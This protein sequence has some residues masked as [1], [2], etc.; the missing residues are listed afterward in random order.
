MFP[1]AAVLMLMGVIAFLAYPFWRKSQ[2]PLIVGHEASLDEER[3]D[4][5]IE[6]QSLLKILSDLEIDSAQGKIAAA[7]YTRL[8][9]SNEHRL[10]AVLD[11]LDVLTRK[12]SGR[13][14]VKTMAAPSR[15]NWLAIPV[16]GLLIAGGSA[17]V[18]KLVYMRFEQQQ[19]AAAAR[20]GGGPPINP[21]EMVA[22][23]E[24][25]LKKNPNDLQGQ[26]MAG[27]SY[28][29]LE[30]WPEAEKAW[31]KVLE[32]D[33]KN[34]TA[35]YSLGEILIRTAA[36]GNNAVAEEA[37]SHFDKALIRL[38]QDPSILWARGIA[39]VQLGRFPEADEAWTQAFQYLPQGTESSDMVKKAL[40]DLR[41]GRIPLS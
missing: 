34:E 26:L 14:K 40:Q 29:A 4:L 6:K 38:P 39:L 35:H 12:G 13:P 7:D 37:L 8:K 11:R 23:L 24:E 3:V 28:M 22:R 10:V 2:I 21:V 17:G 20:E 27:R 18:Y 5:E 9:L 30:R 36:P 1:V 25:R 41:G 32:L 15:F 19:F 16:L 31:R 33:E